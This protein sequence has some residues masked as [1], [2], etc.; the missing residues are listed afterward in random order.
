M[1]LDIEKEREGDPC[2]RTQSQ[3]CRIIVRDGA[4]E[5]T[6]ECAAWEIIIRQMTQDNNDGR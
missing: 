1:I 5:G 2:R 3:R 4:M 6:E